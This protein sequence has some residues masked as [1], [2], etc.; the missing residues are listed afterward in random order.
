[1]DAPFYFTLENTGVCQ[2]PTISLLWPLPEA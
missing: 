1:M 2:A